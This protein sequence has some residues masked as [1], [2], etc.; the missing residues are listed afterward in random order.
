MSSGNEV[1]TGKGA[2]WW[3]RAQL[4]FTP[5]A[6]WHAYATGYKEAADRLIKSINEG[7]HGQDYLVFPIFFLYRHYLE[8]STKEL[9]KKC[10][11]LLGITPPAG[12]QKKKKE[13]ILAAQGHD[14]E[15][16]WA[17]LKE[18]VPG[19]HPDLADEAL[20]DIDRMVEA[21]HRHDQFGDAARYPVGLAGERTLSGL[22]EI[23][24]RKLAEDIDKAEDGFWAI[25]SAIDFMHEQMRLDAEANAY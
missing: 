16:L 11:P 22:R 12:R 5:D 15:G 23:N 20:S 4:N 7:Q 8:V 13:Q 25:D 6:P 9:I 14:L 24:L 18:L 1:F 3:N 2:D 10:Q 21:F 19:I 17:Y